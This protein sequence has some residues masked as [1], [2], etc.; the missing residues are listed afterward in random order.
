[1][2]PTVLLCIAG[3]L[4]LGIVVFLIVWKIRARRFKPTKDKDRQQE[5]LNQDLVNA[6]FAYDRHRDIFYSTKDCWQRE[7]GY[8]RLYDEGASAF[9]MVM[10]CEPVTFS[11]ANKRW[12]IELWKGQ[13][14]I[15][16]G[17]EIGIY[18]TDRPDINTDGF[19]GT[20]YESVSDAEMLPMRFVLR[21]NG[22]VLFKC[23]SVTWWLTGFKLGEYSSP[24][25]LTMDAQIRFPD[26][27]MLQ[28]FTDALT[29]IGYLPHEFSVRKN[30]VTIHYTVPH[31]EQP[32]TRDSLPE[33][34]VQKTNRNN[35]R[36]YDQVTH[37]YSNTLDKLE[38]LKSMAPELYEFCMHSLY[39]RGFY[40]AFSWLLDLIH[41][42][43]R[44]DPAPPLCPPR[45]I[46]PCPPRPCPVCPPEPCLPCPPGP[47]P[48]NPCS[49]CPPGP[50]PTEPC[51]SCQSER[52][53]SNPFN[54]QDDYPDPGRCYN[55]S[56]CRYDCNCEDNGGRDYSFSSRG[57]SEGCDR[58]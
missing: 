43:H 49:P 32:I 44:P 55:S 13:Y 45:P 52:Y 15:T 37:K 4:L 3:V 31:T 51:P 16:T 30:T 50:C 53:F 42:D 46:P 29:D 10:H 12:L 25:S 7:M 11:Y 2:L 54:D 9:N 47:C 20:F 22:K 19:K 48:T 35:C 26:G 34:V 6:G 21:K 41:P 40:E 27:Y 18:N 23:K 57:D 8:C 39:A 24:D 56:P 14:G 36:L 1:M 58:R 33:A 28:A 5:E 38:F 17:G